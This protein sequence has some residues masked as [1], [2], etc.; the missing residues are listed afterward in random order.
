M[1]P[2]ELLYTKE[3]EWIRIN[4]DTGTVGITSHAQEALGDV[5][6]IELPKPG[7][8]FE[9]HQPFGSVESVKAVSELFV[10][11]GGEVIEVNS[12][13]K[14]TPETLNSDPYGNGWLIR[15]R[16]QNSA[17]TSALLS[18]KAYGEYVKTQE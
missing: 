11:V 5:V 16:I 2:E 10:P 7:D 6:Y 12:A 13:L 4:G 8:R 15:L 18:A 3:H 1:N 17:D 14:D 9:S